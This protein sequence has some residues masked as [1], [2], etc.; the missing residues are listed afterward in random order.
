M[1]RKGKGKVFQ[2]EWPSFVVYAFGNS[3]RDVKKR[4]KNEDLQNPQPTINHHF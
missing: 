1:N 2:D 3:R 4:V